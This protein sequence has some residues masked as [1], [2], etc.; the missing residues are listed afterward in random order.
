MK[1]KTCNDE[2]LV[3][4]MVANDDIHPEAIVMIPVACDCCGG[5]SVDGMDCENCKAGYKV[6]EWKDE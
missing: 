2:G 5:W 6:I 1:C 3:L 4:S